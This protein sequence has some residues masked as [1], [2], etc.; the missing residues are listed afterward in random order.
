MFKKNEWVTPISKCQHDYSDCGIIVDVDKN[1]LVMKINEVYWEKEKQ[2]KKEEYRHYS[3]EEMANDIFCSY[4]NLL[5]Y[6]EPDCDIHT[7]E[8]VDQLNNIIRDFCDIDY[9]A[10]VSVDEEKAAD[11]VKALEMLKDRIMNTLKKKWVVINVEDNN[12]YKPDA[13]DSYEKAYEQMEREYCAVAGDGYE[14]SIHEDYAS[15]QSD[16]YNA[17]WRI[18]EIES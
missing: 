8:Y 12:I 14:C 18:Y 15:V 6:D 1:K 3:V 10:E 7:E 5:R 17:D 11:I 4:S 16:C 9:L 2:V 13:F